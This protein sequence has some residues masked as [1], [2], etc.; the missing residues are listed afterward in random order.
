MTDT[1]PAPLTDWVS[2]GQLPG[3]EAVRELV[4][5]AHRRFSPVRDGE[6]AR[7]I[8]A[9]AAADPAHFGLCVASTAGLLSRPVNRDRCSP[10]RACRSRFCSPCSAR[11]SVRTSPATGW[12]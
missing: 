9:L 4:A 5:E 12:V 3:E 2:T 8:P 6:V 11:R 10:F 1:V 7:Y